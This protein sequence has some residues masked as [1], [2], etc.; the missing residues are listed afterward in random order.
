MKK[1]VILCVDD[2]KTVLVSLKQQLKRH[3]G[4]DY[5][6]ETAQDGVEAL[7]ILEEIQEEKREFPLVIS[8][9][10]MPGMTGDELL[11]RFH[12]RS[13]DTLKILL[14]GQASAAAVGNA[15]NCANLYRYISKPW[16]Q[17][18]FNLTVS[19]ALRSYCLNK[20][21]QES[22]QRYRDLY[23]EKPSIYFTVDADSVVLSVNRFGARQLGYTI[24]ELIGTRLTDLLHP[25]DVE[26]G[27]KYLQICLA[28][29]DMLHKQEIRKICKNGSELWM[30]E[31][32]RAIRT[33][34]GEQNV[35]IVGE[36]VS[37][38]HRLSRQVSYLAS[39]D[40]L[41]GLVNRGEFEQHLRRLLELA[42]EYNREHA[43]CYLD[44]DQ[45]KVINDTCGHLAG[46]ELLRQLARIL[47][48][49]CKKRD[50]VARLGG[51]EFGI[52]M[53]DCSL[54]QAEQAA[55][56][57]QN[58]IG[59]FRFVWEDRNFN[60]G[61]SIGLVPI[62]ETCGTITEL[63]RCADSAC[64]AAKDAGRSRIHVYRE[65]DSMVA[66]RHG[67]M[68]WVSRI[69]LAMDE[70]RFHLYSQAIVPSAK[71]DHDGL[72]HYEILVRMED[73]RGKL[74]APNVFLPAAE[75]YNLATK[76]DHWII[77]RTFEWLAAHPQHLRRLA[78]CSINLSGCSL[79]EDDILK[80][81]LRCFDKNRVPPQKICFEITETAAIANLSD[82]TRFISTLK[83]RGCLFG[84]DDFGSGLSSFAY[85]RTMPVDFLKI[86]G[87]FVKNIADDPIDF[88]M[89]KSINEI[90]QVMGK[91]TI[92]EFVES[93]AILEKLREI[94]VDYV[95]GFY[96]GKPLALEDMA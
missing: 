59:M 15:V 84:L 11:K 12:F 54:A 75:H 25:N 24:A 74:I 43:L 96:L 60:I 13:P 63:L 62:T 57:W 33:P 2:E 10:L 81:I 67:E 17:T 53:E 85:L 64:Y 49:Q 89:V 95:Q 93:A 91:Q 82:A 56:V 20:Q 6:I 71:A 21:L 70:H 7:E 27:R 55:A 79:G 28:K 3:L 37:E 52:L 26:V 32:A 73:E 19:E 44:L 47:R 5:V 36:D 22:E 65:N 69:S 40:A 83:D 50:I 72:L 46:D 42:R 90:G 4:D 78:L 68:E 34:K 86:D 1:P 35:L 76:L 30:R 51:D 61:V 18:D 48:K 31:S 38:T 8:D 94:G 92:A 39:H 80:F 23:H 45:F 58:T 41:T 77:D 16:E 87:M 29:P 66:K 14:T 9:H 88:A